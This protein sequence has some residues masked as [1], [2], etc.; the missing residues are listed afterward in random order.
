MRLVA[1]LIF[2]SLFCSRICAENCFVLGTVWYVSD[3]I[4]QTETC[5][6]FSGKIYELQPYPQDEDCDFMELLATDV[7]KGARVGEQALAAYIRV[8]GEKVY[9]KD[10]W[11]FKEWYLMY[12]FSILEGEN[13]EVYEVKTQGNA[14]KNPTPQN[15]Y[16]YDST[17]IDEYGFE[18][19]KVISEDYKNYLQEDYPYPDRWDVMSGKWLKGLGSTEGPIEN[20][21]YGRI[22]GPKSRLLRVELNGNIL[23]ES[24]WLSSDPEVKVENHESPKYSID[25]RRLSPDAEGLY[26]QD[27]K[28]HLTP[29]RF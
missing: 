1:F 25:G 19:M 17:V 11:N 23:Y 15:L 14:N 20:C 22:G 16:C 9:F 6:D 27:G 24:D 8:D 28:L 4:E 7:V 12:D 10:P 29:S 5:S 21:I 3:G 2:V 26:I 13:V 18:I